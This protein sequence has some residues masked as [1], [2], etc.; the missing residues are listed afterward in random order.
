MYSSLLP[1]LGRAD[2]GSGFEVGPGEPAPPPGRPPSLRHPHLLSSH[3]PRP[4]VAKSEV[5]TSTTNPCRPL[6][7]RPEV[8]TPPF[9]KQLSQ[10]LAYHLLPLPPHN[11]QGLRTLAFHD[12]LP[13]SHCLLH[14]HPVTSTTFLL[15]ETTAMRPSSLSA[16]SPPPFKPSP[17]CRQAELCRTQHRGGPRCPLLIARPCLPLPCLTLKS[18]LS[19]LP[20]LPAWR[21]TIRECHGT[22]SLQHLALP[23]TLPPT[24]LPFHERVN[25]LS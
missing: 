24:L 23:R 5:I 7:S 19:C 22:L 3:P 18:L 15:A 21:L 20:L 16:A 2:N 25:T 17:H 6:G 11:R 13:C 9:T 12:P 10:S 4:T 1:N 14:R 8:E